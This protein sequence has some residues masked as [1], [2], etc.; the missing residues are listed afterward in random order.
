MDT[1]TDNVTSLCHRDIY[2]RHQKFDIYFNRGVK[3]NK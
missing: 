2:M 3:F 1:F